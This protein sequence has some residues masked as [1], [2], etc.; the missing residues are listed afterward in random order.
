MLFSV[1]GM[2]FSRLRIVVSCLMEVVTALRLVDVCFAVDCFASR[3]LLCWL[4]GSVAALDGQSL[5]A[6]DGGSRVLLARRQLCRPARSH[7]CTDSL[8]LS[9]LR[10]LSALRLAAVRC[11]DLSSRQMLGCSCRAPVRHSIVAAASESLW[12]CRLLSCARSPVAECERAAA[13]LDVEVAEPLLSPL[14]RF[15]R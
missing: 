11:G 14:L 2:R 8:Q 1:A 5:D 10:L 6:S 12:R 9:L 13:V 4:D 3:S 15:G 7:P